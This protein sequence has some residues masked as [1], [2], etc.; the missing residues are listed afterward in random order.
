MPPHDGQDPKEIHL[1]FQCSVLREGSG[2]EYDVY[3]WF[4]LGLGW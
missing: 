3:V 1:D 4:L 2:T